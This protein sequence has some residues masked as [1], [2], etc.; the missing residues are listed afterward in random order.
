MRV[1]D[2]N[3]LTA[4]TSVLAAL[5]VASCEEPVNREDPRRGES[6]DW[7][8]KTGL[9]DTLVFNLLIHGN[10]VFSIDGAST[11]KL[12]R[13]LRSPTMPASHYNGKGAGARMMVA[14]DIKTKDGRNIVGSGEMLVFADRVHFAM[15]YEE[16]G[17]TGGSSTAINLGDVLDHAQLKVLRDNL[18][19]DSEQLNK[20]GIQKI[21]PVDP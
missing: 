14:C 7:I 4:L 12:K 11:L 21:E 6:A 5:I 9:D 20:W 13:E 18:G 1:S 17:G 10:V 2:F 3:I 8:Y 19:V 16:S 15:D